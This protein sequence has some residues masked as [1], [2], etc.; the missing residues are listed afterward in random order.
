MNTEYFI[1]G[2]IILLAS[3][4][5][6]FS[7][8][9]FALISIPLLSFFLEIK[10]AIPLAALFGLVINIMLYF[11]LHG[12]IDFKELKNLILGAVIGIPFGV[13]FLTKANPAFI[14]ILL[15]IIILLFVLLSSFSL[16]PQKKMGLSWGYLFGIFSGLLGG[17]LNTNG[18]PV[19]IYFFLQGWDKIKQKASVTGF[20]IISS[21][22]IVGLHAAT[23]ISNVEMIIESLYYVPFVLI[24]FITGNIFFARI[25]TSFFNRF[26]LFFLF[27]IGVYLISGM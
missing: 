11:K 16:I 2:F 10:T 1:I 5:Q 12:H 18:P 25:S 21:V 14:K 9:G 23:G 26:V 22:L 24:G 6:G 13:L 19:L 27:L 7:G 20:F 15:G 3:F 4:V 8:F 17:A